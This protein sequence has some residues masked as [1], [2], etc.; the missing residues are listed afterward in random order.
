VKQR[1]PLPAEISKTLYR[2]EKESLAEAA[3]RFIR[4]VGKKHPL[5]PL[6]DAVLNLK[7]GIGI[8]PKLME[9]WEKHGRPNQPN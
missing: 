9:A 1:P 8:W 2:R 6:A 5:Y 4:R 3:K 7:P